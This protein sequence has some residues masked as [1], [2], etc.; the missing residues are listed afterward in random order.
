MSDL[1]D[2]KTGA[3]Y[4]AAMYLCYLAYTLIEPIVFPPIVRYPWQRAQSPYD[5]KQQ[6]Q[7]TVV[8]AGSYNPPHK[9]H[10]AMLQFLSENYKEVIAVVGMN[11]KKKYLVLPEERADMLKGMMDEHGIKNVK[12][13][14]NNDSFWIHSQLRSNLAN[15]FFLQS[16]RA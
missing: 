3:G 9:G 7:K 5:E 4:A 2:W 12:V 10:L 11:P 15:Q 13:Q 6:K 16:S 8:L 1:D 14:G